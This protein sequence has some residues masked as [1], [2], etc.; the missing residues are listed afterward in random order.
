M[1]LIYDAELRPGKLEL[2]S[3]WLPGAR[4]FPSAEPVTARKLGSFRFDDPEGAVGIETLIVAAGSVVVQVPLTYRDA[5]LDGAERFLIGEM[6]HSVLGRRW[7]YDA[8]GDPV[9]A[10]A[11]EA[12]LFSRQGQAPQYTERNGVRE[13]LPESMRVFSSGMPDGAE[14]V[15]APAEEPQDWAVSVVEQSG[16]ELSVVRLLDL[17]GRT[18]PDPSLQATWEGQDFPV[19]LAWG[20]PSAG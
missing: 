18:A 6:E 12:A 13:L 20:M 3:D 17:D 9:Y 11:L 15:D 4:W 2:I 14:L 16:W 10:A 19:V 1:A 7:V 8:A 5:P